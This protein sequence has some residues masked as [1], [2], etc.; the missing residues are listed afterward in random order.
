MT[1]SHASLSERAIRKIIDSDGVTYGDE[2]EHLRY[3]EAHSAIMTLQAYLLPVVCGVVIIGFGRKVLWPVVTVFFAMQLPVWFGIAYLKRTRVAVYS[4]ALRA[5]GRF[6]IDMTTGSF[7]AA[8]VIFRSRPASGG[9]GFVSGA[10]VSGAIG[11]ALSVMVMAA[12]A[13]R[14]NRP[15]SSD[16]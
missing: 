10:I 6:A 14:E 2:R 11:A 16:D 12:R 15:V 7:F 1:T 9:N 8:A 5:R 13:R 3:Y 4:N